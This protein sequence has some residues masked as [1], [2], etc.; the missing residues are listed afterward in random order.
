MPGARAW[1]VPSWTRTLTA[2]RVLNWLLRKVKKIWL[3]ARVC[4]SRDRNENAWC[5]D[6]IQP[7]VKLAMRLEGRRSSGFRACS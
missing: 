3:N 1:R 5:I 6:V 4:Q 2:R 7:L